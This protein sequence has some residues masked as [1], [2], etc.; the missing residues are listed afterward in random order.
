MRRYGNHWS[1][2]NVSGNY[3]VWSVHF[4]GCCLKVYCKT[5]DWWL[6]EFGRGAEETH[7]GLKVYR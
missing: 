3:I 5:R 2:S 4:V 6:R 1:Q 7:G